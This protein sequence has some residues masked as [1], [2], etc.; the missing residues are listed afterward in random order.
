MSDHQISDAV[1]SATTPSKCVSA[2]VAGL[3]ASVIRYQCCVAC[4]RPQNLAKY[5]CVNCG[6]TSLIWAKS[7][8]FGTVQAVTIIERASDAIFKAMVPYVIVL[9][10]MHEDFNLMAIQDP[11][12]SKKSFSADGLDRA[13]RPLCGS[14][15]IGDP[16]RLEAKRWGEH[17]GLVAFRSN[18]LA[19]SVL[20][21]ETS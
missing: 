7:V 18:A 12:E 21:P 16:V 9:V 10:C 8:G 5:R 15:Q 1:M 13:K 6:S 4:K 3:N 2:F 19:E 17:Q 11:S 20:N 14:L